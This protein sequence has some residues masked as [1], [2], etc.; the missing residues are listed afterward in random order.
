MTPDEFVN[1]WKDSGGAELAN[2]QSFLKELCDLLEVAQPDPT[3][4]DAASNRYVFEKAV[5][6]N[7]GDGSVSQGRVDLFRAGCFVLESKQG[8][9]RKAAEQAEALATVTKTAKKLVGTAKRGTAAW[10]RAMQAA[11]KQAKGY[12]EAIPDEWPPFLVVVDVGF[13]FDLYAD[14]TGTGKNYVPFP[15]PRSFRIP[16]LR[17]R[18]EKTRDVLRALWT[19]PHS[20]DPTKH[21]A[22]VTRDIATRLAKLAK[23]LEAEHDAEVV[24]GFLMRCLFTMFAEDVELIRKESFTE[25][26]LSLRFEPDNFKPMV[27]SLWEAMDEG[28]FSTIL[29]EKIRH[30]N[31]KFFKDKTAL[32]L[33]KDQV[34]LLVEA[35]KHKWDLVEP[36]IFGT[37]L[38]RALDPVERH[39]LGAH[40]T[41]RAYVERLVMPTIIE[42]LREQWDAT[43]AAAIQ[44]DEDGKRKDAVKL[45]REFHG[46][47][48]ETRVLDP[49][50]GSGNFLYVSMELMKRLEG[51][52]V[53]AM[54]SFGDHVL[55]GITIDPHQFLG[56]EINPRAAALAEL[57]LWIGFIQWHRRTRNEVA[58]P[59]P[60][61]KD[62]QNIECRDAVLDW[63]SIELVTDDEGNP[64]TRW[65]GRTTK[66]NPVTGEE[67]PDE[68]ARV[69]ELRYINPKKAEWPET[70]YIVGNPPFIGNKR[71]RFALGDGYTQA[72]RATF[73]DLSENVD[74][75]MYWWHH[76]AQLLT[77][78]PVNAFGFITT[79]S[80]SQSSNR[81]VIKPFLASKSPL[82]IRYAV[83]D[84]P[85]VDSASGA[86]VR[87][88]MTVVD[89]VD[90]DGIREAIVCESTN[91]D[92]LDVVELSTQSGIITPDL[93][94]GA[95][96]GN[97]TKLESNKGLSF[98]GMTL[99]GDFRISA[100]EVVELGFS[101][102]DLPPPIK[103]YSNGR[104][105]SQI[106]QRRFAI[107]FY[108]TDLASATSEYPSLVQRVVDHV[109]PLRD[110]NK[111]ETYKRNWWIF[112]E[113]RKSLREGI[114]GLDRY[115]VT[116]ET[117][118]H[119]Y[120]LFLPGDYVPDHS[121]FVIASDKAFDLGVLNSRIHVLWARVAGSRLG[122]GNDLRWRNATC[123][124]PFPY[125]LVGDA[126]ATKQR[127]GELAEQLDAHRKRQQEQHPTLT[128]TGMYNVLEKLRAGDALTNKEQTIHEQGLVSVLRQIHDD[129]DAAVFDAYGWPHDL[130]DEEILQRLVD[131]NHERSEEESRGI[132]RWLRPEFQN[133]DGATQTTLDGADEKAK[134]AKKAAAK[135]KK[136]PWPK[137]L[138]DRMVA[139][140]AAL[141]RH[142][143]PADVKQ[144]AAYY[145]RAK[146]DDVAE[147]LETLAAVG[148][149]RQLED[150]RFAAY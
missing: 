77:A 98:M 36:A 130:A 118:K 76:A 11:R 58:P 44:L 127:I 22:D 16:L 74:Y 15:D 122:V 37:L 81:A 3:K 131:L 104:E 136:Q 56:I 25:L 67:V 148:N 121:L 105:L 10:D 85:W 89:S 35:A 50:C 13:C 111:R 61:L 71:M 97:A 28:K 101:V 135:V 17:L 55:P 90:V 64:V 113:P 54:A 92:G 82:T 62:Y 39:K 21:A 48:C 68:D 52:V 38:E 57:V 26:L 115:I 80:I 40:Y 96:V 125:P 93:R 91:E 41:P 141:Q 42:P 73:D 94:I 110:E 132:V 7:N 24:A 47:L 69:Q 46:K 133:P 51:E 149:V 33:T 12:A 99:V 6:F 123:F 128:M 19:D 144:I 134:P 114:R 109:K 70:D 139:I 79:N 78:D 45:L 86:Q 129:L 87:I 14:F 8:S 49:A 43:Y 142:A 119:R 103:R 66:P 75:V 143:A 4:P 2:S 106:S 140:Q 138:P 120:F 23:S 34:E 32:T 83:P 9:E 53:S 60:I 137:T 117:S 5:E 72:L 1:R 108:G 29:R 124:D 65:D 30:F 27:E 63:D 145:T 88:A 20:L 102:D 126:D 84:H 107:D 112:G 31:G 116:L 150:G 147:L 18:D 95:N 100:E 146:K 59:E